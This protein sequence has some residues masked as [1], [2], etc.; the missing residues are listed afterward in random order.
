MLDRFVSL[1]S[2]VLAVVWIID[3][4]E[5]DGRTVF[6]ALS[7]YDRFII[8]FSSKRRHTNQADFSVLK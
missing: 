5:Y 4:I 3:Q 1:M 2:V 6:Q 7:H 8:K